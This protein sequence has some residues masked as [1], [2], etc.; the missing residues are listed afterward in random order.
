MINIC[1]SVQILNRKYDINLQGL[2][3]YNSSL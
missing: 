2:N 3:F 1:M